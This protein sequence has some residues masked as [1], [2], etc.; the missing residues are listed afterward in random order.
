MQLARRTHNCRAVG[1]IPTGLEKDSTH[2]KRE[3]SHAN[4]NGLRGHLL[5]LSLSLSPFLSFSFS[6]SLALALS[7]GVIGRSIIKKLATLTTSVSPGCEG[8]PA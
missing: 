5:S 1:F 2:Y 6:L 3:I 8:Q 4:Q 7:F